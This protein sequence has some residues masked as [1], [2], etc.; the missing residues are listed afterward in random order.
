MPLLN[1][2]GGR[3]WESLMCRC[4][5][6]RRSRRSRGR[7]ARVQPIGM[8]PGIGMTLTGAELLRGRLRGSGPVDGARPVDNLRPV[9]GPLSRGNEH[10]YLRS[11][12]DGPTPATVLPL[13]RFSSDE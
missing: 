11:Y 12:R 7:P 9:D 3:N 5:P 4:G 13:G 8:A 2:A 10:T 1:D 6:A